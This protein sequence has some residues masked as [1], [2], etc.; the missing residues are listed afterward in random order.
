L[1]NGQERDTLDE[2]EESYRTSPIYE[3]LKRV[4]NVK[5]LWSKFGTIP[6][7][8]LGGL[9]M[10]TNQLLGFSFFGTLRH[11]KPDSAT[12]SPRAPRNPSPT[13]SRTGYHLRQAVQRVP[14]QHQS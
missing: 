2:Y 7:V 6:G 11:E 1:W 14:F 5:P 13:P 10:W 12:L 4:R 9:D 3:D 8:A